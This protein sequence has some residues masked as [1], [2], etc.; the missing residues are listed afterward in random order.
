[1]IRGLSYIHNQGIIHNDIKPDNILLD[2]ND[3]A[4]IG[5]FGSAA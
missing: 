5:D 4:K 3:L 1:M 2:E